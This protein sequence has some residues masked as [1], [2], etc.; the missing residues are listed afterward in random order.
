MI[1]IEYIRTMATYSEWQNTS[2]VQAA[3][4]LDDTERH[5]HRGAFF[6]SIQGTM[7]HLL[8]GDRIWM[9]KFAGTQ[10]PSMASIPESIS[11]T[12]GWSSY[13]TARVAMDA[14]ISAWA[15]SV[16]P[17][18]LQGDLSWFSG[19]VKRNVSKPRQLLI[20][21]FFNHGTHHRGQIHSMLTAAGAAP[22]DTDLPFM[23]Q[24]S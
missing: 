2:I 14:A 20:V 6:G 17:S 1:D 23:P 10:K 22:D 3:G 7:N 24:H 18:W 12:D 13:R 16:D 9:H 19:A 11:E 4:T 8:W 5:K 15:E 21:H